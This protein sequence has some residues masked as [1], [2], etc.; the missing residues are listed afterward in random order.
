MSSLV[1]KFSFHYDFLKHFFTLEG[2]ARPGIFSFL[3]DFPILTEE[4]YS[5]IGLRFVIFFV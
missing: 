5:V 2:G 3:P 1:F 4:V